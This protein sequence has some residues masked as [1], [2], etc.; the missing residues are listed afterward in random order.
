MATFYSILSVSQEAPLEDIR[1]NYRE[2]C[3]NCHPDKTADPTSDF[4][5]IQR[6][7]ETLRDPVLRANYD[8]NLLG[9]TY[10]RERSVSFEVDLDDM[11]EEVEAEIWTYPCRYD[12][13][14]NFLNSFLF[15]CGSRF[16]ISSD[17]L[18]Q[19]I[20]VI[21]CEGCSLYVR[22]LFTEYTGEEVS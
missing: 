10:N 13:Y 12:F 2:K 6:A 14:P 8:K 7:W 18:E 1:K 5:L 21:Q 11:K 4:Q 22:V 19:D 15:R 16:M 9:A 3:L 17:C 20:N